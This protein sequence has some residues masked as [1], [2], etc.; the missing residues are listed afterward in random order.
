[1]PGQ[2]TV[3]IFVDF[4]VGQALASYTDDLQGFPSY[5]HAADGK[6]APAIQSALQSFAKPWYE[7]RAICVF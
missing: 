7:R 4:K 6:L 3:A 1:V 2:R 5:S